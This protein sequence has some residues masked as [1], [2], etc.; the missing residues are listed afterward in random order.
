MNICHKK[1]I[2]LKRSRV[3][4][5]SNNKSSKLLKEENY[6]RRWLSIGL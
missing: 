4:R 3:F 1:A 5:R 2:S 6:F